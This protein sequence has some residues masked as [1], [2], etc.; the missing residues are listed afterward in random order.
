LLEIS[1]PTS[2]KSC[3]NQAGGIVRLLVLQS[4]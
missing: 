1:K 2:T 4:H 3:S